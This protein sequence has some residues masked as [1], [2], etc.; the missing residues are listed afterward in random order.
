MCM[1]ACIAWH[2][3]S[4]WPLRSPRNI[5][6][7][8]VYTIMTCI[9]R[10]PAT[11]V[12][13]FL[14]FCLSVFPSLCF[15]PSFTH[16]LSISP[17]AH[18][19]LH[20]DFSL[21]FKTVTD[22]P[23]R[24]VLNQVLSYFGPHHYY[25]CGG[26]KNAWLTLQGLNACLTWHLSARIN[27]H[28]IQ[29][30]PAWA[31]RCSPHWKGPVSTTKRRV[32]LWQHWLRLMSHGMTCAPPTTAHYPLGRGGKHAASKMWPCADQAFCPVPPR[33]PV[34]PAVYG[35]QRPLTQTVQ[36]SINHKW[37]FWHCLHPRYASPWCQLI[38]QIISQAGHAYH[39]TC[40]AAPVFSGWERHVRL[41]SDCWAFTEGKPGLCERGEVP[42]CA[43]PFHPT[44]TQITGFIVITRK[45]CL[46]PERHWI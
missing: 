3:P 46:P 30:Q 34:P 19:L 38:S 6:T 7:G 29:C 12:A 39:M 21:C 24:F 13:P 33:P 20:P 11:S 10:G 15:C 36:R 2:T 5:T 9:A 31:A 41:D 44:Q 22:F 4:W 27:K 1:R 18:P 42:T 45:A 28:I 32:G 35:E 16:N 26:E 17:F 43:S 37:H 8:A 40:W 14:H 25:Q 23:R